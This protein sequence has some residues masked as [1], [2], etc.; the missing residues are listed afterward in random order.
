MCREAGD[1]VDGAVTPIAVRS[2]AHASKCKRPESPIG[3][4]PLSYREAVSFNVTTRDTGR[5]GP[6]S[7]P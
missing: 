4:R 5:R 2:A 3:F 7:G 6:R 1:E